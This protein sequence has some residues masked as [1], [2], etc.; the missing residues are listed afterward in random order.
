MVKLLL[1]AA[2]GHAFRTLWQR[3]F[4]IN[5]GNLYLFTIYMNDGKTQNAVIIENGVKL[6]D[7]YVTKK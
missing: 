4:R 1:F 6:I 5:C 2:K 3:P 7:T